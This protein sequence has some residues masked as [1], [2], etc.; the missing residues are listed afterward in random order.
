L[1]VTPRQLVHATPAFKAPPRAPRDLWVLPWAQSRFPQEIAELK[2]RYPMDLAKPPECLL[3]PLPT[4][5]DRYETGTFIDMWGN[6]YVNVQPGVAGEVKRPQIRDEQ[7]RDASRIRFPRELQTLDVDKVNAFCAGTDKFVSTDFSPQP[8]QLLQFLR[9]TEDLLTD[10]M[11]RPPR[12]MEFLDNVHNFY[13]E[14]LALWAESDVDALNIVDDWGAQNAL[15]IPPALW[16]EVFKP[17]YRDY[18]DIAHRRGKKI[19][20]H[21][22]GHLLEILEDL[23][24]LGLDAVNS[25]IFCMGPERLRPYAGRITFWGEMD[26]QGLLCFGSPADVEAAVRRVQDNLWK[27]GGCIAQLEF[28]AGARPE[29]VLATYR[30]WDSLFRGEGVKS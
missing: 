16:R 9:G 5:G 10:L 12:M 29:N 25:Q 2:A 17:L 19:F 11:V 20:M 4:H 22:D 6:E 30:A 23:V 28:G 15:L 13:C 7:W 14:T 8:F 1:G 27:D 24:E 18:I 26:R 21:S 3:E